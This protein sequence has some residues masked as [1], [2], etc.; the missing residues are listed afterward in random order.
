[1]VMAKDKDLE[2]VDQEAQKFS[3]ARWISSGDLMYSITNIVLY[4]WSLP[5]V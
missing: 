3:Y 2:D 4:V 5:R 1:M